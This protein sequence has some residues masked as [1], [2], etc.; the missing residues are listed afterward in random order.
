MSVSGTCAQ[1]CKS[2]EN[3]C[4]LP[5]LTTFKSAKTQLEKCCTCLFQ[6]SGRNVM[7]AHW[8]T[9]RKIFQ[10]FQLEEKCQ[11]QTKG[12]NCIPQTTARTSSFEVPQQV[13]K[14]WTP[15][16]LI[17]DC[18]VYL[19]P[20]TFYLLLSTSSGNT[21]VADIPFSLCFTWSF[22]LSDESEMK[23]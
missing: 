20:G 18:L 4:P 3:D 19:E 11:C 8:S 17:A 10:L 5:S 9:C 13:A 6:R 2:H 7:T 16:F 15:F 14:Q 12:H 22:S 1:N 21:A 23:E